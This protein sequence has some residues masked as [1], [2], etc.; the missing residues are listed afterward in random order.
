MRAHLGDSCSQS[1]PRFEAY[2]LFDFCREQKGPLESTQRVRERILWTAITHKEGALHCARCQGQVRRV[3]E[4]LGLCY[5]TG[6]DQELEQR[7]IV[8]STHAGRLLS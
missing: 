7:G 6:E 8:A 3:G 4:R 5:S 2:G 1:D